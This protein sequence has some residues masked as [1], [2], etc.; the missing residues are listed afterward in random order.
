MAYARLIGSG[1]ERTLYEAFEVALKRSLAVQPEL[2]E[3]S[4]A[5]KATDVAVLTVTASQSLREAS[6]GCKS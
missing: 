4:R 1:E 3:A 5:N 6:D 2:L